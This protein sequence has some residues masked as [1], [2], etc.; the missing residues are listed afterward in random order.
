MTVLS[1]LTVNSARVDS[2]IPHYEFSDPELWTD[3]TWTQRFPGSSELRTYFKHVAEKWNL[4]EDT[5]FNKWVASATCK[6]LWAL[7]SCH[8][9]MIC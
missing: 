3:W 6:P 9:R 4:R 7:D 2:S 8:H 5:I 1:L